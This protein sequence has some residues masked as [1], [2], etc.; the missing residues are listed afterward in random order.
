MKTKNR[1]WSLYLALLNVNYG[2]SAGKF[3]YIKKRQR[4]WEPIVIVVSI[5]PLLFLGVWFVWTLTEKLFLAGLT[6]G[7][8]HLPLVNGTLMVSVLGLFF[9]FF[10]VLSAFYFSNDLPILI[11]L[12]LRSWEILVAKVA[13]ILSGQYV[14]NAVFL[15]PM[16]IRYG[17]LAGVGAAYVLAA[18]VVFAVL[19]VIPLVLASLLAV[20]L[21]RV[22]NLS[23][24]KDK[25]TLFGGIALLLVI[26]GF[27][28]WLQNSL[29]SDDPNVLME[30]L[31]RQADGLIMAVGRAFPP[32]LWAAQAMAYAHRSQGWLNLFYLVV[33]GLLG[34]G[35]LYGLGEK[36]F[37]QGLLAGLEGTRG[38]GK[39]R[40]AG[41]PLEA[42]TAL[43]TLAGME[44]KLF[45]RDPNFALNGLIGYVLLPVMALL[46]L[47]GNKTEG[48]PFDLLNLEEVHPLLVVGGIALVFMLMTAMSLIPST[49]FSR[50]GR[51]LWIVRCMPVSIGQLI[52]SRVLAAQVINTV[53]CLLGVIPIAY[54]AGWG[55]WEVLFGTLFG[56]VLASAVACLL[57]IFDLSRPMLDWVNPVKAVKSNLNAIIG[58]TVVVGLGFILGGLLYLNWQTQTLWLIPI[59]FTLVSALLAGLAWL[60]L[61]RVAPRLWARI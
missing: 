42:R 1:L 40:T 37:M 13:V 27:Q 53:G 12:P 22:V 33:T 59:E 60:L 49:T 10:Y 6:F 44:V 8:P 35:L 48:N 61:R 52:T 15:L 45:V 47:L 38:S 56:V 34:L 18:I 11:P 2:W 17:S 23:R 29:G 26:F 41:A 54:L 28:Y 31:L 3:Y 46:P 24:H 4:I 25:L 51:Y 21:M 19:P 20:V 16:W 57:A 9:G 32:S 50:E 43:R 58:L 36:V 7:Q 55:V 14:L 5:A 39:R 30:Q